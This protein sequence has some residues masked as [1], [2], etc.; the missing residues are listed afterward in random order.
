MA[1]VDPNRVGKTLLLV[2]CRSSGDLAEIKRIVKMTGKLGQGH[3]DERSIA[4][5]Q[6]M[7]S[8]CAVHTLPTT[9]RWP[10]LLAS[11]RLDDEKESTLPASGCVV[12]EG[13]G[14]GGL[15]NLSLDVSQGCQVSQDFASIYLFSSRL[16][17]AASPIRRAFRKTIF[18]EEDRSPH[19]CRTRLISGPP[20]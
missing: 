16:L 11:N 18:P 14:R 6:L 7:I 12:R 13:S 10:G 8:E 15:G 20:W 9:G 19:G 2:L 3:W 5:S 4:C 17:H 1:L